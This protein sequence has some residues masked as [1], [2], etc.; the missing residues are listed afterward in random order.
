MYNRNYFLLK[1]K[2]LSPSQN[3]ADA[4]IGDL[5]YSRNITGPRAGMGQFNNF[6]TCR[7]WQGTPVDIDAAKLI[8][9]TV[10]SCGTAKQGALTYAHAHAYRGVWM[11]VV[12]DVFR[13]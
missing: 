2:I 10:S 5:Q 6:L 7:V 3:F 13:G 9:P 1:L 4:A 8:Y 11:A 12:H